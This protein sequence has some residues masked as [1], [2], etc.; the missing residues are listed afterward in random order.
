LKGLLRFKSRLPG[1]FER[2]QLLKH[3]KRYIAMYMPDCPFEVTTTNR[4]TI[5]SQEASLTA[6]KAIKKGQPV[7]YLTGIH[8]ELTEKDEEDLDLN[9]KDFSIVMSSRRG[10]ATM[11]LGPARFAN[12]DCNANARLNTQ[13]T[14][15]MTVMAYRDIQVGEEITVDYGQDYFGVDNCE[16]LCNTCEKLRRNGWANPNDEAISPG[17]VLA[18]DPLAPYSFRHK[19]KS[20]DSASRTG[21]PQGN[22]AKRRKKNDTS[23]PTGRNDSPITQ[24]RSSRAERAARRQEIRRDEKQEDEAFEASNSAEEAIGDQTPTT[25]PKV[26]GSLGRE[27]PSVARQMDSSKQDVKSELLEPS[28]LRDIPPA[29]LGRSPQ[30]EGSHV[31]EN[32]PRKSIPISALLNETTESTFLRDPSTQPE[33]HDSPSSTQEAVSTPP[34]SIE[35][36]SMDGKFTFESNEIPFD[37]IFSQVEGQTV[38][39]SVETDVHFSR[40]DSAKNQATPKSKASEKKSDMREAEGKKSRPK[41]KS[42]ELDMVGE[43]PMPEDHSSNA[44]PK[45]STRSAGLLG[46]MGPP[47]KR[48]KPE[49]APRS[50]SR[51]S[52]TI[53]SQD[54]YIPPDVMRTPGDYIETPH[55]LGPKYSSWNKCDNCDNSFVQADSY[56]MRSNCPRCERHSKLYGYQ[57]PKTQ[58]EGNWDTEERILDHRQVNRF[59]ASK[60]QKG[61][62]RKL[63]GDEEDSEEEEEETP[64]RKAKQTVAVKERKIIEPKRGRGRPSLGKARK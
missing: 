62:K 29:G 1:E 37:R 16:C 64:P 15:N 23:T 17:D 46:S 60:D 31:L 47:P 12:H 10:R 33:S 56:L 59:V 57:W 53:S 14:H 2:D 51:Q 21:T 55:L 9:N 24:P 30:R 20:E 22:P 27:A 4:F 43:V 63:L 3:M 36:N 19:R 18:T 41:R 35:D 32:G 44:T 25:G 50:R 8:V 58:K 39:Y 11:F 49:T 5:S 6:R 26:N 40:A 52:S 38:A 48:F 7:K 61:R 34:T 28:A 42:D 54:S 45:Q 13:G